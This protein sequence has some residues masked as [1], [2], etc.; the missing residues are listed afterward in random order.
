MFE[1]NKFGH[2]VGQDRLTGSL[3]LLSSGR[4]TPQIRICWVAINVQWLGA[5]VYL[6]YPSYYFLL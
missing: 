1:R 6:R 3:Y 2:L 5:R 4:L